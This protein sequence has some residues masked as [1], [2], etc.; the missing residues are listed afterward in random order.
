M[1]TLSHWLEQFNAACASGES[2]AI[3][4]MFASDGAWR[5]YL[6]FDLNLQTVEGYADIAQF[7]G[8][9]IG[10]AQ[11]SQLEVEDPNNTDEGAF[12]F[13]T[14]FGNSR[15]YA[16]IENGLCKTLFTSLTDLHQTEPVT[17]NQSSADHYVLIVGGGQ[18]GLALGAQLSSLNIPYLI[19]DKYPKV[20]DQWRSR[21]DSLVL[22]DPVWYDHLPIKPF[23]D[24]WPVFTPKDQMGDWLENYAQS[25][26]LN[27]RTNCTLAGATYQPDT[28]TWRAQI[29][30][31]GKRTEIT[32]THLV[33][34]LGLSGF[35]YTPE[36]KGQQLFAGDQMHSSDFQ[37]GKY[38][39]GKDVVVVGANNSA[40]D[41]ASDLV[42]VGARPVMIQRSSTLVV[43]QSVYCEKL[44]GKL[45]S[46]AAHEQ[47]ID[48]DEADFLFSTVPMRL[49]E[50]R[51][52][53][54][55][56]E[57]KTQDKAYY[58]SIEDAGFNI[59]FA[60]DGTGLGLKYRRTAS[61]YYIDVGATQMVIDGR[62]GIRSGVN[63]D[64]LAEQHMVLDSGEQLA[65]DAIVYATGYGNMIDWV[66]K[67][68]DQ[69]TADRVGPCW[70]Y[71]SGTKGDPGPWLG[72]LRNMWVP[73]AQDGLWFMGGNLAQARYF[74]KILALQLQARYLGIVQ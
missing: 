16:R 2:D 53:A 33:M 36:F 70:G 43:K 65:A 64:H 50:T 20:G 42:R 49:L 4:T 12:S 38:W 7:A 56:E 25:L 11:L 46:K 30:H 5:D 55:W 17:N 68:I 69:E 54:L 45:Y 60:E 10:N 44:L 66:A 63:V 27:I 24:D 51:H 14:R 37:P 35:A 29:E 9:H 39:S 34:A 62:I 28:A 3:A 21:Y 47:G 8:K 22:H 61:G 58:Q 26:S 52:R 13:S 41:I 31:Q 72:E 18:G 74:S 19:I 48:A 1:T 23:P 59:D 71:G 15:G 73:T 40:H 32:A 67:L 6:A 57:I